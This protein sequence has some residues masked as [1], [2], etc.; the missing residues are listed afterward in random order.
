MI[1]ND[2]SLDNYKEN[3]YMPGKGPLHNSFGETEDLS[4]KLVELLSLYCS[5]PAV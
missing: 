5:R 4:L 1:H 2:V 3:I